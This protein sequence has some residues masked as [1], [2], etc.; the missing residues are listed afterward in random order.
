MVDIAKTLV[1]EPKVILLD[2]PGAGLNEIESER[3]KHLLRDMPARFGCQ[4]LLIDHDADLIA[5][6]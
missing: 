6:P 1:G 2:E 4:L 5:S 3:L